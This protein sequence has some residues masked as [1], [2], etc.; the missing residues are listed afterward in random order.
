MSEKL[1]PKPKESKDLADLIKDLNEDSDNEEALR[2]LTDKTLSFKTEADFSKILQIQDPL[3]RM[4]L[5]TALIRSGDLAGMGYVVKRAREELQKNIK[6][7]ESLS[8]AKRKIKGFALLSP[9]AEEKES[10]QLWNTLTE[11]DIN[12]FLKSMPLNEIWIAREI[13]INGNEKQ[14]KDVLGFVSRIS[15]TKFAETQEPIA[16][17]R[18]EHLEQT[19]KIGFLNELHQDLPRTEKIL[20]KRYIVDAIKEY[21]ENPINNDLKKTIDWMQ[22]RMRSAG[23]SKQIEEA[24]LEYCKKIYQEDAA[25]GAEK[26]KTLAAILSLEDIRFGLNYKNFGK[27]MRET[28]EKFLKST[29]PKRGRMV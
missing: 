2:L 22:G 3:A 9:F 6:D 11:N 17:R 13:I 5:L 10:R 12:E 8:D 20:V 25:T 15:Y 29:Q 19:A 28:I 27:K 23:L 4:E 14:K 26:L 24:T 21:L 7:I 16:G 18:I 1:E